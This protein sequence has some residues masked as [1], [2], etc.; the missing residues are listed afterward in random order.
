MVNFEEVEPGT[1]SEINRNVFTTTLEQI[2][3]WSR[4]NSMWPLSFGL[5]CCA[6]EMMGSSAGHYDADRFGIFIVHHQGMQT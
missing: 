1:Q 5:A 6:I 2:K 3:A 4:S